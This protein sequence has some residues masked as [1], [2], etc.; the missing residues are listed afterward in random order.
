MKLKNSYPSLYELESHK[1]CLVNARIND[2]GY[3]WR[4]K[5]RPNTFGLTSD[6][7]HL[8]KEIAPT[9]LQP[10][11][12]Y[13]SCCL[14]SDG[15]Y[16]VASLRVKLGHK[17]LTSTSQIHIKWSK[18]IPIK[19]SS[20]VWRAVLRHIPS[21]EALGHRGIKLDSTLCGSCI[22]GS[23]TADHI[24]VGCPYATM[25]RDKI[26]RWCGIDN[27]KVQSVGDLVEF[28]NKWG[29]CSKR[30]KILTVIC[31]E[32]IW[33]LWKTRN[34]RLFQRCTSSPLKVLENVKSLVYLWL[35]VR[36]K[37]GIC[38]REDWNVSPFAS[39]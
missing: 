29:R 8:S 20:F 34:E 28:A 14:N 39:Y 33:T 11:L 1:S 26:S 22:N 15:I 12:D 23:E 19:V 25:I 38:N 3:K 9:R 31:Y 18:L 24:I 16:N 5:S 10:S 7:E 32:L 17:L 37:N 13:F 6:L 27:I 4:W 2:S 35:K 30:R 36:D 21:A